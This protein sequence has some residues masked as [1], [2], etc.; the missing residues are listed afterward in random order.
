MIVEGTTEAFKDEILDAL[1]AIRGYEGENMR[2]RLAG[3]SD[4]ILSRSH[5]DW[6]ENVKEFGQWGRS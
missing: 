6:E 3:M 4:E 5:G 1:K 2:R